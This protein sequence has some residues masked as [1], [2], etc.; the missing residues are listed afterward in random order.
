MKRIKIT[1]QQLHLLAEKAE[2]KAIEVQAPNELQTKEGYTTVF[3]AGSIEMGK[4][5]EWQKKVIESLSDKPYIF[6]NPRRAD[7]DSTWK[8]EKTDKNFNEQ[9]TW[10][11]DAL[12][13]ADLIVMYFDPGTASPISLLELG[14][15]ARGGKLVVCC[16][17]G[18]ERKGNVDITCE[19]YQ[20]KQVETLDE[21]IKFLT[22]K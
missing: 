15:H 20:M 11:L 3:L 16:P 18:F 6:Y 13:K 2:A 8:Q 21:L 10:E 1:E 17:E 12:E 14:L 5:E 19:K 4:A 7:W 9:V 22:E